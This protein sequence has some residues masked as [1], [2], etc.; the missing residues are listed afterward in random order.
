MFTF[1]A[2]DLQDLSDDIEEIISEEIKDTVITVQGDVTR[3]TPVDSGLS[4]SNWQ[5]SKN[6]PATGVLAVGSANSNAF[7]AAIGINY[8]VGETYFITNNVEYIGFVNDGTSRQP[9]Q[10]FV[11]NGITTALRRLD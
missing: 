2:S 7:R 5:V 4:R 11:E 6:S 10:F 9:G 1:D 3:N 8:T